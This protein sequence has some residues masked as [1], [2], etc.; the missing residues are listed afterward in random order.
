ML[1]FLD[2]VNGLILLSREEII[3]TKTVCDIL[4]SY[5]VIKEGLSPEIQIQSKGGR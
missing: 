5:L 4:W 1:S 2:L 3:T